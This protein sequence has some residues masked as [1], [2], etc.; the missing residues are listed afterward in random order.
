MTE[1]WLLKKRNFD[2][3]V[4]NKKIENSIIR[5][6]LARRE[7]YSEFELQAYLNKNSK[8]EHNPFL[9]Q[10]ME[11]SVKILSEKIL[12]GGKV[13]LALDYDVDGIISGAIAFMALS[14]IGIKCAYRFPHRVNEGYGL[15]NNIVE[16]ARDNNFDTIITFDNGISSFESVEYAK[17]LG[18]SIIVTDHHEI[19]KV[20]I[21]GTICERLVSADAIINPKL[22]SCAYP[23]K[24]ICGAMVAYKLMLALYTQLGLEQ[25]ELTDQY[26]LVAIATVCDVMELVDE[27]RVFVD[28]GLRLLKNTDMPGI[29]AILNILGYDKKPILKASD[30]AFQIGPMLNASGRLETADI[31][32]NLLIANDYDTALNLAIRLRE[33]NQTRKLMTKESTEKANAIIDSQKLYNNNIV[34]VYLKDIHESLAG[35]VAG[36]IKEEYNR[37]A[38]VFTQSEDGI[39]GSARATDEINIFRELSK[40]DTFFIK[41][42]GHA[43]AAGLSVHEKLFDEFVS[44]ITGH[45]NT[46]KIEKSQKYFIDSIIKFESLDIH[47][48]KDLEIFEPTGKGN[49]ALLFSSLNVKISKVIFVGERKNV[50]KVEF[51]SG[52]TARNFISFSPKKILGIL[53][54]KFEIDDEHDIMNVDFYKFQNISFDIL[55]K[56][57]INFHNNNEYLNLELISIR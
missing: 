52:K 25:S 31:A 9:M 28:K 39:K 24:G 3:K 6:A 26:G 38:I 35:I 32:L 12:N 21:E 40:Y 56:I 36:R 54:T 37:T 48:A 55:Y 45:F 22:K 33:L 43:A 51:L 11:K 13:L 41:Y 15:N 4:I 1:Q 34:I 2:P 16:Y 5:E 44:L 46:Y 23:Y 53:K 30:L 10:G 19:P 7:L 27:N 8:L 47:L 14:K 42:G 57:N 18:I 20:N 29:W 49:P 50:L 17:E